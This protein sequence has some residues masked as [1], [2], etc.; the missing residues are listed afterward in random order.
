MDYCNF[1][2][3]QIFQYTDYEIT[4]AV[5]NKQRSFERISAQTGTE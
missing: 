2:E 5:L 1:S 3:Q 4:V